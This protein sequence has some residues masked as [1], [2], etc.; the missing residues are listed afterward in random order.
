MPGRL[1]LP[2][3]DVVT[4]MVHGESA[5][6]ALVSWTTAVSD[7]FDVVLSGGP[8]FFDVEQDLPNVTVITTPNG[9]QGLI[10]SK[11]RLSESATGLHVGLNLD[12]T[13]NHLAGAGILMRYSHGAI[14]VPNGTE[15]M[16]IGGF[17]AA[18]GFRL[19][20]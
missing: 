6:Y 9:G 11:T 5:V 1:N 8:M 19:K 2:I 20:L 17:Q 14:D 13:F 3:N 10:V 4:G 18:V 12:Y 7:R 15:S 16:T